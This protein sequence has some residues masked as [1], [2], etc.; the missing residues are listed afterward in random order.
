M[1]EGSRWRQRSHSRTTSTSSSS[2]PSWS[3]LLLELGHQSLDDPNHPLDWAT[4]TIESYALS[5]AVVIRTGDVFAGPALHSYAH[6]IASVAKL[7]DDWKTKVQLQ[8]SLTTS[9]IVH[10]RPTSLR[11]KTLRTLPD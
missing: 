10:A 2:G 6:T 9:R 3:Q 5:D 1:S 8:R 7:T 11:T 4:E